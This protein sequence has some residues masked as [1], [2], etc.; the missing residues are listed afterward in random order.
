MYTTINFLHET[1]SKLNR[2]L[3][4]QWFEWENVHENRRFNG[5]RISKPNGPFT[6]RVKY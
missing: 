2:S 6:V 4:Q 3:A 5:E 1:Y